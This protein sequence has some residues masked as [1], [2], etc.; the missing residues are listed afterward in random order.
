MRIAIAIFVKNIAVME[1]EVITYMEW[2]CSV[3]GL[4]AMLLSDLSVRFE[5]ESTF[6]PLCPV[7]LWLR[8]G[9]ELGGGS[10]LRRLSGRFRDS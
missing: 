6:T 8:F 3:G 7:L 2:S 10:V 5:E 9:F 1:Q 4:M